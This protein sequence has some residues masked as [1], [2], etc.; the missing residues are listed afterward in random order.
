MWW[1]FARN[2]DFFSQRKAAQVFH[3]D[4]DD[5][6]FLKFFFYI[7]KVDDESG[8]HVFVTY[9]LPRKKLTHELIR[10]GYSDVEIAQYYGQENILTICGEA[11][12][13]FV[14][15][16]LYF[17]KGITPKKQD[18]L[19]LQIEYAMYD[20]GMQSDYINPTLLNLSPSFTFPTSLP[21]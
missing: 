10:R 3:Y 7:T 15:D 9:S 14:E 12:F 19:I 16:P 21:V 13:G 18:R 1:S 5:S 11:G 6:R 2:T 20:Y 17:H 8:P 4:L